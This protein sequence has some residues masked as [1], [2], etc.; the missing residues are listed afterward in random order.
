MNTYRPRRQQVKAGNFRIPSSL[1][2]KKKE[3]SNVIMDRHGH[4]VK[5]T[6]GWWSS[7]RVKSWQRRFRA[8]ER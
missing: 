5:A 2:K 4:V 1:K 8:E 6:V 7:I 3:K